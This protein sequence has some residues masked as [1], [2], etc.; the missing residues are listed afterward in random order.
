MHCIVTGTPAVRCTTSHYTSSCY[1]LLL[2]LQTWASAS[3]CRCLTQCT[4]CSATQPSSLA[5]S[6]ATSS[7]KYRQSS[8]PN[9]QILQVRISVGRC[10]VFYE[11][12]G[13]GIDTRSYVWAEV[14]DGIVGDGKS[15]REVYP[16]IY[17]LLSYW[18]FDSQMRRKQLFYAI[19]SYTSIFKPAFMT[20]SQIYV[21]I[22]FLCIEYRGNIDQLCLQVTFKAFYKVGCPKL[23]TSP[24]LNLSHN[25]M[26]RL[27]DE[28]SECGRLEKLDI[29]HNAFVDIPTVVFRLPK[30]KVLLINSNFIIGKFYVFA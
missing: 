29:S 28:M 23:F 20:I 15:Q 12:V 24:E 27:P 7:R 17:T 26:A 14:V 30:I 16:I 2:V 4:T 25:K 1:Q 10:S 6:L 21:L 5:T 19:Y 8:P 11:F 3:L 18:C 22:L 9:S 13:V